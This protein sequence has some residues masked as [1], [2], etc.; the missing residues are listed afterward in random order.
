[1]RTTIL[2]LSAVILFMACKDKNDPSGKKD[3]KPVPPEYLLS[4]N[5]IGEIK[6]G[7]TRTEIEKLLRQSLTMWHAKDTGDTWADTAT[8]KYRDLEVSLY[9]QRQYSETPT[10]E[11][12]LTGI[13]TK[14]PLCKTA[15]GLGVGDDRN[16][17]L[18]AYEDNPISMGPESVMINDSTWGLSKT[19]YYITISDSAWDKQITFNLVNKKIA[20]VEAS[21]QMGD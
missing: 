2:F 10:T 17:V 4:K 15:G 1:M 14:S 16:A 3:I 11:M 7:M 21:I 6:I 8:A 5:G 9:F 18:A 12:E 19:N 20:S 13:S